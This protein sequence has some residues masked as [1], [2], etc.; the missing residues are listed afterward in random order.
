MSGSPNIVIWRMTRMSKSKTSAASEPAVINDSNLS[1][2][3]SRLLLGVLDGAGTEVSPLVLSVT[4][5]DEKG[6]VAEDPAVRQALDQLLKR[7]GRLKVEDVAFTIFPQRVWEM[8]RGDRGRLFTLYRATF[9]RWQAMNKKANSRGLYFERLVM[10]GRGPCGGNQLEWILSQFGS[11]TGVRRSMLQATTFDP[12][13]DHVA[14]AQ[15]GFPCLQ[16]VSFEPTAAGLVVNAFYATQQ[17]FDK[18]YGNYLGLAQLGAFMAHEMGMPL[19][20]LNVMVGVAKLERI[21]KSDPD[22]APIV[23]AAEKFVS[24]A[25][26]APVWPAVPVMAVGAAS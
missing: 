11:R 1:R 13:R 20:R 2:A 21:T 9:P 22:F 25:V 5:F 15:L 23:A 7:K 8:S 6:V 14:S 3:W 4:G 18:A 17:I 26:A 16:Q 10:Y 12:G 19:A 24:G